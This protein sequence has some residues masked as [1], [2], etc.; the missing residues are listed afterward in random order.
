MIMGQQEIINAE[1][2]V[3]KKSPMEFIEEWK[4][5]K[6]EDERTFLEEINTPEHKEK[7]ETIRGKIVKK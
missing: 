6:L 1:T 5:R 4:R 7:I 3:R 2:D